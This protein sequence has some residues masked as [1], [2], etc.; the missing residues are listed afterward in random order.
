MRAEFLSSTLDP[1]MNLGRDSCPGQKALR[2]ERFYEACAAR[3]HSGHRVDG[4]RD[5][6]RAD[7]DTDPAGRPGYQTRH[8]WIGHKREPD[9]DE[10]QSSEGP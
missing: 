8:R 3:N 2:S 6:L 1:D 10:E 7:V 5:V 9:P 4:F